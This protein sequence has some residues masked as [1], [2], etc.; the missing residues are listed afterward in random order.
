MFPMHRNPAVRA[1]MLPVLEKHSNVLTIEPLDYVQFIHL[2]KAS[3]IV[4]TGSGGVQ[5]EAPSLGRP[6][7]VL[8]ENTERPE[9]ATAGT[10]RL[11]GTDADRIVQEVDRLMDDPDAYAA[12]AQVANPYGDGKAAE[13]AVAA[14]EHLLGVGE[15]LPDSAPSAGS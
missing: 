15:R 1:T 2:Q 6:V 3:H 13:R 4:L 14:I 11:V 10:V 7:L 5:E 8:R 12:M 9:A